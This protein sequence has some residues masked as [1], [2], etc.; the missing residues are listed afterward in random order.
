MIKIFCFVITFTWL[1]YPGSLRYRPADIYL[2]RVVNIECSVN[3]FNT[4]PIW[5]IQ[6]I[7]QDG[8]GRKGGLSRKWRR[9]VLELHFVFGSCP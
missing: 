1:L 5:I 9:N 8:K 3:H 7:F 6:H 2:S 4:L